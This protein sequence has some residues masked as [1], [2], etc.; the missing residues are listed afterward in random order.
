MT[1]INN[2]TQ[3]NDDLLLSVILDSRGNVN[4]NYARK[5]VLA[6]HPALQEYLFN[7][8]PDSESISET[9][10]RIQNKIE[11]RPVCQH[12]GGHVVFYKKSKGFQTYCSNKC[13]CPDNKR[14]EKCKITSNAK[15]GCDWPT[16]NKEICNKAVNTKIEKYGKESISQSLKNWCNNHNVSAP[17]CVPEIKSKISQKIHSKYGVN[18]FLSSDYINSIR[19]NKEIIN[20]ICETKWKNKTFNSS[21]IEHLF[22]QYLQNRFGNDDVLSQYKSIEYPYNCDFYIKSIHL[23]IEI[24]GYWTHGNHPYDEQNECDRNTLNKWKNKGSK[25]YLEAIQT[26]TIRDV[27]KRNVA[28]DNKLNYLEI[29]S[30][31]LDVCIQQLNNYIKEQ[32]N[33]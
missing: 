5:N 11:I 27:E 24:Q 21:K 23:Y 6:K 33:N 22:L 7:R 19:C 18:W 25:K 9:V 14:L 32:Y 17:I 8:F 16:Q 31:N 12:C 3:Y 28:K 30:T 15:Y 1:N 2:I 29:F 26:W 4:A 20:K 10:Y 13:S